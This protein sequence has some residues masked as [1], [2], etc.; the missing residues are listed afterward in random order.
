MKF[1]FF[2]LWYSSIYRWIDRWYFD[3]QLHQRSTRQPESTKQ[4]PSLESDIMHTSTIASPLSNVGVWSQAMV[5]LN[6]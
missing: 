2:L 4:L 3:A 5:R 6:V 1:A